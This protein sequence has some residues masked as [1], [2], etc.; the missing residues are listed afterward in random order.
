VL[1]W[2]IFLVIVIF[3]LWLIL[4]TRSGKDMILPEKT[5]PRRIRKL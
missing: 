5:M 3:V 4:H 1:D 2:I